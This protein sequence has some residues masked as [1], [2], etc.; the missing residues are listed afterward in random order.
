MYKYLAYEKLPQVILNDLDVEPGLLGRTA[1][2]AFKKFLSD[3]IEQLSEAEKA[4][5]WGLGKSKRQK[6]RAK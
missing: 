6:T 5:L 1:A 3:H 4:L 2:T